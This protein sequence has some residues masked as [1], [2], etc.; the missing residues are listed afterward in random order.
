MFE[1]MLTAV[2]TAS[3]CL[4]AAY[5]VAGRKYLKRI[6][7]LEEDLRQCNETVSQM[8]ELQMK[9]YQKL[10]ANLGD[11]EDRLME[12]AIP[13]A[14]RALPL[15]RRHNVLALANKGIPLDEIVDRLNVPRG[16]AELILSLRKYMTGAAARAAKSGGERK[17][18]GHTSMFAEGV[19]KKPPVVE[20]TQGPEATASF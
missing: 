14:E 7:T 12:L 9:A 18:H 13:S 1:P 8:A 16:E 3:L 17:R 20:H 10:S 6:G 15:E 11:M 19:H 5:L 4:G 2:L